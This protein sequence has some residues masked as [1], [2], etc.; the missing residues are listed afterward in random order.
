[1]YH[2]LMSACGDS[3]Y[4]CSAALVNTGMVEV[5]EPCNILHTQGMVTLDGKTMSSSKR[6]GIWVGEFV[7]EYGADVARL[8]VLFAAPARRTSGR[9]C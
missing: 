3:T 6:I 1:M 5:K 8:A 4:S 2:T 9:S 7:A